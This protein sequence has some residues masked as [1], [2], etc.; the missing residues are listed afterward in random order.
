MPVV[1][2]NCQ[3]GALPTASEREIACHLGLNET[4]R[5]LTSHIASRLGLG[6]DRILRYFS[7]KCGWSERRALKNAGIGTYAIAKVL[8][9][10]HNDNTLIF[11]FGSECLLHAVPHVTCVQIISP[12]PI[13]CKNLV[14]ISLCSDEAEAR[15]A[16]RDERKRTEKVV[17]DL[18]KSKPDVSNFDL[19]LNSEYVP[20]ARCV[21]L[22]LTLAHSD[23]KQP[24]DTS[25]AR[26]SCLLL[27]AH[28]Q[29]VLL[30]NQSHSQIIGP[31]DVSVESRTGTV[32]LSGIVV[33][34]RF[35][36]EIAEVIA[37]LPGVRHIRNKLVSAEQ[38]KYDH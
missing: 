36:S 26:L 23:G 7:N 24:T 34:N 28:I 15:R 27:H 10:A 21:D 31:L 29:V 35:R 18:Y 38:M 19:I 3:L 6:E 22:I 12:T 11:G 2:L 13:R 30:E 5:E 14:D 37:E 20:I 17:Y 25:R 8:A 32:V 16:I 9:L 1:A 4:T 33:S